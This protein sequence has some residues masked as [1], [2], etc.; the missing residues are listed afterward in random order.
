MIRKSHIG[1]VCNI[2]YRPGDSEVEHSG[3]VLS[4]STDWVLLHSNPV[5]Y[6]LDGYILLRR[7][8]ITSVSRGSWER[9]KD[10]LF[11]KKIS[12]TKKTPRVPL[13]DLETILQFLTKEYGVFSFQ[14]RSERTCWLGKVKH[15]KGARLKIY[16]MGT[17]GEWTTNM[18]EFILGNIKSIEFD[19]DYI[20]SLMLI[21]KK[22]K[23]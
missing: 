18:P 16:D 19:T 5:D 3:I 14:M 21:S 20:N 9:F 8:L 12:K 15:I 17:R 11:T 13:T 1:K 6:E 22:R 7:D 4:Y 10:I 23:N 2:G